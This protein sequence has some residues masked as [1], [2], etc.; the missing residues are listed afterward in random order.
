MSV[1][2]ANMLTIF[3]IV[4]GDSTANAFSVEISATCTIDHLKKLIKAERASEFDDIAPEELK[5]WSVS[6]PLVE[7]EEDFIVT[8]DNLSDKKEPRT[9]MLLSKLFSKDPPDD[10]IHFVVVVDDPSRGPKRNEMLELALQCYNQFNAVNHWDSLVD[11]I[12]HLEE[13]LE[14][15][16]DGV[17]YAR[18]AVFY[19]E[20]I[21]ARYMRGRSTTD[22]KDAIDWAEKST[23]LTRKL[24]NEGASVEDLVQAL[25]IH[26]LCLFTKVHQ[27]YDSTDEDSTDEDSTDEDSMDE[28]STDED[29]EKMMA[30]AQEAVNVVVENNLTGRILI[31]TK[32]N[33]GMSYQLRWDQGNNKKQY[34]DL[35]RSLQLGWEVVNMIRTESN[36]S[37]LLV[38]ALS[39]LSFRLQRA[40]LCFVSDGSLPQM[41]CVSSGQ[42]LLDQAVD[43]LTESINSPEATLLSTPTNTLAFVMYIKNF[44]LE[45][46]GCIFGRLSICLDRSV[47]NLEQLCMAASEEDRKDNLSLFYG[48]SRYAAAARLH[49]KGPSA[50]FDALQILEKGRGIAIATLQREDVDKRVLAD[51]SLGFEEMISLAKEEDIVVA[52]I[53]DLRSDAIIIRR[54]SICNVHLP[55]LDEDVLSKKSWKIQKQLAKDTGQED[56]YFE[57]YELLT[58]FLRHLWRNLVRPVVDFLGYN[59]PPASPEEWPHVRWI[60]TGVLCLYPIHAAG[61]GLHLT[62]NTMDMVISTYATSLSSLYHIKQRKKALREAVKQLGDDHAPGSENGSVLVFSMPETPGQQSLEQSSKEVAAITRVFPSSQILTGSTTQDVLFALATQPEI[63]HFSCHGLVDYDYPTQ[64]LLLTSDWETNPLTVAHL[65]AL[66]SRSNKSHSESRLAFLSACFTANGGVENEQD[67]NIHLASSVQHAGFSNVVGSTWYVEEGAALAVV[68]RF[69]DILGKT[70]QAGHVDGRQVA[71]ALHFAVLEHRKTTKLVANR[72]RGD[73]VNW[74]PFLCFTD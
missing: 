3:C 19:A 41:V 28:D 11:A 36:T 74:A 25:G 23:G 72:G 17:D 71:E 56:V 10:T 42:D 53:T 22:L 31:E 47:N 68:E 50:A 70:V 9:N 12:I 44:P 38:T 18:L 73:P 59:S 51:M 45:V 1:N 61:L 16:E 58:E 63:V 21:R 60:P 15:T 6:I 49:L 29:F 57:L 26:W 33:L 24:L 67:E 34:S 43:L 7:E 65:Q 4:N 37:D 35:D 52:N 20:C 14:G 46:R 13:A 54:G 48:I 39:N 30:A 64:S 62:D 69:Y 5:L 2:K 55:D 27:Q 8:L 66:N 40:Y 32:G